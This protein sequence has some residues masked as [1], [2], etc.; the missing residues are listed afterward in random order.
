MVSVAYRPTA[1]AKCQNNVYQS[2]L[3]CYCIRPVAAALFTGEGY[4]HC[5]TARIIIIII[6]TDML[7]NSTQYG[8]YTSKS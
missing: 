3:I 5:A 6:K 2:Y 7:S 8:E 4:W 1:G